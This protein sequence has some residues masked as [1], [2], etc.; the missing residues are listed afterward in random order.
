[1]DHPLKSLAYYYFK[2]F[3]FLINQLLKFH[4][5]MDVRQAQMFEYNIAHIIDK[6][7][8]SSL[9]FLHVLPGA[10]SAYRYSALS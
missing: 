10:W 7:F 4:F 5:F 9:D 6:N 8:E 2:I 3:D 1:M